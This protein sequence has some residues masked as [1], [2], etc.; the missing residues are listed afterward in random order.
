MSYVII[1][2]WSSKCS[3]CGGNADYYEDSHISGGPKSMWD[4]GSSLDEKNGCGAV[5]DEPAVN[6]YGERPRFME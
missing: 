4:K 2:G 5:W 3:A 6:A 1:G